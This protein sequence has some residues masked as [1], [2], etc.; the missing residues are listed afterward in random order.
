MDR[1]IALRNAGLTPI[2]FTLRRGGIPVFNIW[3]VRRRSSQVCYRQ[4]SGDQ[5][6]GVFL[7]GHLPKLDVAGSNPVSRSIFSITYADSPH[8]PNPPLA[9]KCLIFICFGLIL[10]LFAPLW[11][12]LDPPIT[13]ECFRLSF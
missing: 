9:C 7:E 10:R 4:L 12:R 2:Q 8:P 1:H 11:L 5:I 3:A 13:I 6:V